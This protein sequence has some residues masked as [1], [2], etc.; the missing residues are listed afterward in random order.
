MQKKRAIVLLSGGLDSEIATLISL[1][2]YNV[3]LAITF[4]YGQAA[5]KQEIAAAK[6][7]CKAYHIKHKHFLLPWLNDVSGSLLNKRT[8]CL[9]VYKAS[10]LGRFAKKEQAS[11]NA[12]WVP[13]RNALFINVVAAYA[14]SMKIDVI[15]TG[16]NK[17]EAN[18]FP[19][20][21][22]EFIKAI[23]RSLYYST[24]NHV[25][26]VSPCKNMTKTQ[27]VKRGFALG[28][29][30][31]FFWSCYKGGKSMCGACESCARSIRALEENKA[32]DVI[33]KRFSLLFPPHCGEG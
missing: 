33:I 16:F 3:N 19:D 13:N 18:T 25:K 27:I 31:D 9:P 32:E 1:K 14:E 5:A 11:A 6:K 4:D 28:L 23:N 24:L 21:S 22:L 2:K 7:F 29:N 26:V 17:E 20:N 10:E 15:I 30:F 12:V 8:G